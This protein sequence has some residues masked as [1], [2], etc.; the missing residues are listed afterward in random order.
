MKRPDPFISRYSPNRTNPDDL[1]RIHVERDDLLRDAVKRVREGVLG[2]KRKS[3]LFVGSRGSGKTH[4]V[5]LMV[6]RIRQDE[7]VIGNVRIAWLNE[8]ETSLSY[9][10]LLVR[11]YRA[12]ASAYRDEFDEGAL[13]EA[14]DLGASGARQFLEDRLEKQIGKR[15]LLVIVENFDALLGALGEQGQLEWR[16]FLQDSELMLVVA[17][18]QRLTDGMTKVNKRKGSGQKERL[19][20]EE[21]AFFGFFTVAKMSP[22]GVDEATELLRKLARLK[23]DLELED[24]LSGRHGRARVRAMHHLSGGNPRLY[25]VLS[26]FINRESFDELVRPFEE[27]VD[28]RLTPYYQD[29]LRWLSAQQRRLVEVLCQQRGPMTVAELA[30]KV[31]AAENTVSGQL[32]KLREMGYVEATKDQRESFYELKEPMMRL[33]MQVKDARGSEPL[34]LLVDFLKVWFDR[35]ELEQRLGDDGMGNLEKMY[36]SH[37]VEALK[38]EGPSLRHEL[39]RRDVAGLNVEKCNDEERERLYDLAE[40]TNESADLIKASLAFGYAGNNEIATT[41]ASR[42][43]GQ[44]GAP[45]EQ[46]AIA[47]NIRGVHHELLGD[48]DRAIEDYGNVIGLVGVEVEQMAVALFNRGFTYEKK[49]DLERAVMEYGRVIQLDGAPVEQVTE[50]LNNRGGVI[51]GQQRKLEAA[52]KDF[53]RVTQLDGPSVKQVAISLFNRAVTYEQQ[54]DL[55][56]AMD[57]CRRVSE[58]DGAPVEWVARAL[59]NRGVIQAR[60]GDLNEAMNDFGRVVE[61]NGAPA[62]E[63][64]LALGCRGQNLSHQ[65]HYDAALKEFRRMVNLKDAPPTLVLRAQWSV[66]FTL[67][68]AGRWDQAKAQCRK[69]LEKDGIAFEWVVDALLTDLLQSGQSQNSWRTEADELSAL[70]SEANQAEMLGEGLVRQLGELKNSRLNADGLEEWCIVWEDAGEG[71]GDPGMVVGLR[72]LRAGVNYLKT[73]QRRELLR[74]PKEERGLVIQ[75]LKLDERPD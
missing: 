49:G 34:S 19:V 9:A 53:E 10:E 58:L 62:E 41:F 51:Y 14:F 37:A 72:L 44:D 60:R 40:E 12:L 21:K 75:A 69:I 56:H 7:R 28:E 4:L 23:G 61:L 26:E 43:I 64:A 42:V 36:L 46:K 65:G 1:E 54:G 39:L 31:F 68:S 11:I 18:A 3:L 24:F 52:R 17:T 50:A 8:D 20:D 66:W 67:R 13:E 55:G 27:M 71:E 29:R 25:I 47:L 59:Y 15:K 38:S 35:E 45:V 33:C 63:V 2:K 57:D 6:H 32:K 30:K 73:G 22:F 74:L 16:A 70:L 48:L 5:S